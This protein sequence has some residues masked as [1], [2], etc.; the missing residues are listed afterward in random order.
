MVE[1]S[2][3]TA[4]CPKCGQQLIYVTSI[5]YPEAPGM[6]RTTFVCYP[7]NRTWNYSLSPAMAAEYAAADAPE[8]APAV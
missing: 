5:P 4:L 3:M 7:C 1:D 2:K 8:S 6:Q